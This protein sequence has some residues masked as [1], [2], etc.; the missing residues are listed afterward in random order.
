MNSYALDIGYKTDMEL[1]SG[2]IISI[3]EGDRL[4]F[5]MI[6]DRDENTIAEEVVYPST[7]NW[8][9]DPFGGAKFAYIE[10][11][12]MDRF[13]NAYISAE[14]LI[15]FKDSKSLALMHICIIGEKIIKI[16]VPS[17]YFLDLPERF[18]MVFEKKSAHNEEVKQLTAGE[19]ASANV[20]LAIKAIKEIIS[21]YGVS[22]I[23]FNT[24][25]QRNGVAQLTV[26]VEYNENGTSR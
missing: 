25:K 7:L 10:S 6:D 14:S 8:H 19:V 3:K 21:Q 9:D 15:D 20:H 12:M 5:T 4:K 16:E 11:K 1:P 2:K 13:D 18:D 24:T 17:R 22:Q 23:S 26:S